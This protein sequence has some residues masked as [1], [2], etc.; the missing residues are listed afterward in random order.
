MKISFNLKIEITIAGGLALWLLL[1][2]PASAENRNEAWYVDKFCQGKIE[3][4][5]PDR[6]RVDCLTSTHAIEYDWGSKWEEGIGQALGYALETGRRPGVVLIL[7]KPRDRRYLQKL[8]EIIKAFD[9]PVD[10]WAIEA[11]TLDEV[12]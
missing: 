11:W 3:H 10:T 7:K 1:A 5:L 4:V 8:D 6:T 9:L 2:P 12:R